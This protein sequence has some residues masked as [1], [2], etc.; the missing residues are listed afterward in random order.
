M[1]KVKFAFWFI[2]LVVI[3]VVVLQNWAYFDARHALSLDLQIDTYTSHEFANWFYLLTCFLIGLLFPYVSG[4][5]Q[6][7]RL[8]KTI[9]RLKA[10]AAAQQEEI[11]QL[12]GELDTMQQDPIEREQD[13]IDV[14]DP[15]A[16]I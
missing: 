5:I 11:S 16:E 12:K 3:G 7:F 4:R 6:R 2:F 14:P 9:K 10:T 15:A 1:K 13:P 8:N